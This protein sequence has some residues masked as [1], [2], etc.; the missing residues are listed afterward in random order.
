VVNALFEQLS[1]NATLR[2]AGPYLHVEGVE[3]VCFALTAQ[4]VPEPDSRLAATPSASEHVAI[5]GCPGFTD[6]AYRA[7]NFL[8]AALPE[9]TQGVLASTASLLNLACNVV[10]VDFSLT[11]FESRSRAPTPGRSG[12]GTRSSAGCARRPASTGRSGVR[13]RVCFASTGQ[14]PPAR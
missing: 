1:T 7:I 5:D 11:R 2:A 8:L 9:V 4:R 12:A 13:G 3:R 14:L 10:F 6:A